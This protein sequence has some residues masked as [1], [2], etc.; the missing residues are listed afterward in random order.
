[1]KTNHVEIKK[2]HVIIFIVFFSF[3]R[4]QLCST[5]YSS[6]AKVHFR[7]GG[8]YFSEAINIKRERI[9]SSPSIY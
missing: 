9:R 6:W 7:K 4:E 3:E 2:K 8:E 5:C 1:M